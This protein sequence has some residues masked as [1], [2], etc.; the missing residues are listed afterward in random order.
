MGF[1]PCGH[2]LG[3]T[4]LYFREVFSVGWVLNP[5]GYYPRNRSQVLY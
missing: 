5:R 1:S 4:F 2:I 3:A